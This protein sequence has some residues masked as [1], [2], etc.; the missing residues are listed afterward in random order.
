M[1]KL[2]YANSNTGSCDGS[3]SN[4]SA[5]IE[6]VGMSGFVKWKIVTNAHFFETIRT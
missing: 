3:M 4:I 2:I 1:S 5:M 6:Q